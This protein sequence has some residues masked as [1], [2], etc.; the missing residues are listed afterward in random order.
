MLRE[1][2]KSKDFIIKGLLET[3]KEIK[4]KSVSV[5]S[6][7]SCMSSS[8]FIVLANN[9]VAIEDVCNNNEEIADTNDEIL[10]AKKKDISD[11]QKIYAT[12]T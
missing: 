8:E 3:I 2:L 4:T 1:E 6:I 10:I 11:I 9:S 7:T 12:P 5:E